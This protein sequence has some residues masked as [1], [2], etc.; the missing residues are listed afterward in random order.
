M[1]EEARGGGGEFISRLAVKFCGGCNPL[2]ER[3][4]LARLIRQGL[5]GS[6]WIPWE[7]G[8]DLVLIING[9]P[10][11]C[12]ERAEIRKNSKASLEITPG[13]VSGIEKADSAW[14]RE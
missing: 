10:T 8:P 9:C 11:A 3:G 14:S 13:G 2:F 4:E 6:E 1:A 12:A 7:E 5:P